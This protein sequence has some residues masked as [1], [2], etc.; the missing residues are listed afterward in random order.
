MFEFLQ[1]Q[2]YLN[3]VLAAVLTSIT[4]GIIGTYI[5]T[6][7]MVFI[8]G[9]ISHASFGGVGLAYY[10]GLDPILG[11]AVFS[12]L[13]GIA[14]ET[15]SS[16][17]DL[18]K[19][20]VIGVMWSLG[21]AAGIIFIFLTP[22]YAANLMTYLF[23][24]ILTVSA[25]DLRLMGGLLLLVVLVFIFLYK[26]ILY[27]AFD[28]EYAKTVGIPVFRINVLLLALI[29]LTIVFCIRVVGIILVI[30]MLTI[31]QAT[32]NM[33][34]KRFRTMIILSVCFALI[35]SLSGLILSDRLNIP[36]GASIIF[37]AIILFILMRIPV[38]L[39]RLNK[40]L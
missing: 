3:A 34:T 26:E 33:F 30:S 40:K 24:N 1:Y 38:V 36:S 25:T 12:V 16:G 7:R 19:D 9:G 15:L 13:S 21:M 23:G 18:R 17:G 6:R 37:C 11:A 8:S 22:G 10:L 32:A 20:T 28:S 4:C 2:F 5:V 31:P 35:S 27:I 29:A 14:I 39:R